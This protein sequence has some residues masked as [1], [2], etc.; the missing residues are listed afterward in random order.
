LHNLDGANVA[1]FGSGS[2]NYLQLQLMVTSLEKMGETPLVVMPQ[3][4][5]N[6]KFYIRKKFIQVLSQDDLGIINDL[7]AGG[8]MYIVPQRCL[9]DYY[10]VLSSLSDQTRSRHGRDLNVLPNDAKGRWPGIRPF[11]ITND[12]MRD[13]KLELLQ[14][15]LFRR[16]F[17]SHIV[18]YSFILNDSESD[19]REITFSTADFFSREISF[20]PTEYGTFWHFPVREWDKNDRFCLRIPSREVDS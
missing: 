8:K 15:R 5:V 7:I 19:D 11:L 1:Y 6:E 3:K 4:Y 17:S 10:W 18:N 14:P 2:I 16:W 20:H 12:L 9:D 13:H